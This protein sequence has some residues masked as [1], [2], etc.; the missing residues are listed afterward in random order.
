MTAALEARQGA[1]IIVKGR[2]VGI[3]LLM[4]VYV[5]NYAD[6]Q[7]LAV[8]IEPIKAE[9]HLS[10]TQI[11]LL[12][13]TLFALFYSFV[14][15]PIA[16]L[17]D[18]K[19]RIRIVAAGCFLWSL[20]TGLSGL[21]TSFIA[22]AVARIGVAFGE[23][24]GVAPSLSVLGDYFSPRRRVLAISLFTCGTPLGILAGTMAGGLIAEA[25]GWRTV[26]LLAAA[27]G[28][29]VVPFL[30]VF[31]P[32]PPRGNFEAP[33]EKVEPLSLGQTIMLF[34]RLPTLGWMAI[35]CGLFAIIGNGL[36]TWMPAVLMRAYGASV[37]D[38]ALY[39]GPVVSISLMLGLVFGGSLVSWFTRFSLRAYAIVPA[40][41]MLVCA[42]LFALTLMAGSWQMALVWMFIPTAL[43]NFVVPPALTLVQNLAPAEARSTASAVLML[44]L[45]LVGI[46]I[47]P[48]LIGSISDRLVTSMGDD[49][50]RYA[51]MAGLIPAMI[52]CALALFVAATRIVRDHDRVARA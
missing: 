50:L 49:G 7:I 37:R 20:F 14:S 42:P 5:L 16:M 17:A 32:E 45:N 26:F 35:A 25:Y 23:A 18:R 27:T 22:L 51:M 38:V 1:G 36:I 12:T 24:G 3:S 13:G 29:A 31:A 21:A 28:I 33:K 4:L 8:L 41:A 19:N 34:F 9:I 46:G 11:G 40:I 10:D 52:L 47:G 39:Y 2:W 15:I 44:V 30:L 48:V 6:R 43:I